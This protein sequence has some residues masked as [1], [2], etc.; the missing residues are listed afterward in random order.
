MNKTKIKTTQTNNTT[1]QPQTVKK[2]GNWKDYNN[3]LKRRG[4]VLILIDEAVIE[5]TFSCPLPT[6]Q[7]GHPKAYSDALILLILSIR[8][9]FRQPLRQTTGLAEGL[10]AQM[11]ITYPVPDYTTLSRRADTLKVNLLNYNRYLG[12]DEPIVLL[13]DGS[14]FKIFGE[15]EWKV[16]KHGYGDRHRIWR[17]AHLAL[18]HRTRDI[19][20][21]I[22]ATPHADEANGTKELLVDAEL[23]L[24]HA[25]SE[26]KLSEMI[27]DGAF[28]ANFLYRDI[29]T[30][31]GKLITPPKANAKV[32]TKRVYD[33][34]KHRGPYRITEDPDWHERNAVVKRC[35]EIGIEAWKDEVGYHRRSLVENAF[36]R[37]KTIFGE[38]LRGRKKTTQDTE[39]RIRARLLNRFNTYGLPKHVVVGA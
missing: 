9:L 13:V 32:R 34:N 23:N 2:I 15:G 33:S 27:G 18:D 25:S 28:D 37:K 29:A 11:N 38:R 30:L 26:R 12:S 21:L 16:K 31:G 6:H 10:F 22:G 14:G 36:Y 7:N 35:N 3:A 24:R 4:N 5:G 1:K 20:G 17:E 39:M 8:E 19:I